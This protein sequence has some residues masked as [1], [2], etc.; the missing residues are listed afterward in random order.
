MKPLLPAFLLALAGAAAQRFPE[1]AADSEPIRDEQYRQMDRYFEDRIARAA[2]ARAAYW[3][4][5][6]LSGVAAFERSAA[7]Y[8]RD[9]AGYLGVPEP[10]A[11]PLHVK[12]VKVRE[13]A[14]HAAWRVW[15]DTVP[16]VQAYGIL[17]VPRHPAGKKPALLCVHGHLGTPEIV[18][19]FLPD[20]A[21]QDDI[22]RVFGRTA[23]LR[24]Y[25][26]WC[27]LIL[28]YYSEEREPAEGPT[29]Q[30][31]DLLHKKALL[32]GRTL[33]GLEA[34]KLRRA[35]DFLQTLPEVDP[36]RIGIYGLSKG[37]HYALYTAAL[38]PRL[39]A[40]VVSGGFN[41]RARK[42]LVPKTG[43]G[44]FFLTYTH[45]DEYF[46]PDLLERFGDAEIAWMVAPRP[47]MIE[48]GSRDGAVLIDDA[49]REFRRVERVYDRLGLADRARF[50]GFDGPHQIDGAQAWP[51]LDRWLGNHTGGSQ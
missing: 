26:V 3:Q 6:D 42:L 33:M 20:E 51:F 15:F 43:P 35:V 7:S 18:A 30:G 9:W 8:R 1:R 40:T 17:L 21:V 12:R 2:T 28:G 29:A 19:G 27:P 44:M 45:R 10:G 34:A 24:G 13:F 48:N 46:L 4:R 41:D 25:V 49:R 47:L 11:A 37:G 31:R 14:T 50:A 16:G 22:Y 39:Q 23:V 38:E 36:R 5:L 32:T